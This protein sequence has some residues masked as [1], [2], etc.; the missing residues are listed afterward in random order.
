MIMPKNKNKQNNKR[1]KIV[2]R[3]KS[4]PKKSKNNQQSSGLPELSECA[5]KYAVAICDPWSPLAIGC[6]VPKHPSRPSQKVT[7][8]LKG[9]VTIG[10]SG[11][12]WVAITPCLANDYHSVCY[13]ASNYSGS[14]IDISDTTPVT[15]VFRIPIGN[16]PYP[17]TAFVDSTA[18]PFRPAIAGRI[19]S[20]SLSVEYTGTELNRGGA[21]ICFTDPDHSS[22][23]QVQCDSIMSRR[24]AAYETSTASRDKCR[25]SVYGLE[26]SELQYPDLASAETFDQQVLKAIY[27]YANEQAVSTIGSDARIGAPIMAAIMT[28]VAGNTYRFEYVQHVEYIGVMAET[29]LTPNVTDAKGFE[30]VQSAASLIPMMKTQNPKLNLRKIMRSALIKASKAATSK[31]AVQAGKALLV[32]ALA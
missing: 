14:N 19:V 8:Y 2:I 27:P 21:V 30:L 7:S 18:G 1:P 28:G 31:Q 16:Q 15:G 5:A 10:T 17:H 11:F 6:C 26:E 13:T 23:Q 24:E 4:K 3:V 12:G 32:A 25:V 22:L 20:G 9:T 29:M